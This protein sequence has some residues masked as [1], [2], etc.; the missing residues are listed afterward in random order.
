[1]SATLERILAGQQNL[2]QTIA[3]SLK[4]LDGHF[5]KD[6][7][8]AFYGLLLMGKDPAGDRQLLKVGTDGSVGTTS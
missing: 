4:R 7:V 8:T 2:S 6:P 3:T 1:M 5:Y